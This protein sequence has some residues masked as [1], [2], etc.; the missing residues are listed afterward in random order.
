MTRHARIS[1]QWVDADDIR[2]AVNH[3]QR[4]GEH[5]LQAAKNA[6]R[7]GARDIVTDAKNESGVP[8]GKIVEY[9]PR[10]NRPFLKPAIESNRDNINRKIA[11]ALRQS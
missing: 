11:D 5:V 8:Y 6:L 9:S 3:F 1:R 7:E 4:R 10:I 2:Q